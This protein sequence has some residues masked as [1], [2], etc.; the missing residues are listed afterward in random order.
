MRVD[1]TLQIPVLSGHSKVI[2][3][4]RYMLRAFTGVNS[5]G[6]RTIKQF[7]FWEKKIRKP[8]YHSGVKETGEN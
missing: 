5:S 3:K 7:L 2:G 6:I 8:H 4:K 1:F